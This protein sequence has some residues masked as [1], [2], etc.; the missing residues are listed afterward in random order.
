MCV[1]VTADILA[2]LTP[3]VVYINIYIY[4]YAAIIML[5]IPTYNNEINTYNSHCSAVTAAMLLLVR[6]LFSSDNNRPPSSTNAKISTVEYYPIPEG[7]LAK[8]D[9]IPFTSLLINLINTYIQTGTQI[10]III[11][12]INDT[13]FN[14]L[15]FEVSAE[16]NCYLN[17]SRVEYIIIYT[18]Y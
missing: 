5:H 16:W 14:H 8:A 4:K 13:Q 15:F 12:I 9:F 6:T 7:G 2:S 1:I 17:F 3:L 10:T 11:I 18:I